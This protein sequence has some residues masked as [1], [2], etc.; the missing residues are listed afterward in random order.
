MIYEP[1]YEGPA[2]Y[3]YQYD[4]KLEFGYFTIEKYKWSNL[5]LRCHIHYF[6]G[7]NSNITDSIISSNQLHGQNMVRNI[8]E[9][10]YKDLSEFD[11]KEIIKTIFKSTP[12]IIF[13]GENYDI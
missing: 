13:I 7:W 3:Y 2:Y 8:Y 1:D 6:F 4:N 11:Y 12:P 5:T 9:L 10:W